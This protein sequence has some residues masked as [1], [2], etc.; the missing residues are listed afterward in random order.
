MAKFRSSWKKIK[1]R[2]QCFLASVVQCS[3]LFK[4]FNICHDLVIQNQIQTVWHACLFFFFQ[5]SDMFPIVCFGISFMD[6]VQNKC[7]N[8][9]KKMF[10]SAKSQ[11]GPEQTSSC[12]CYLVIN[13]LDTILV[14]TSLMS[15]SSIRIFLTV[16]LSTFSVSAIIYSL[17]CQY[18]PIY[19]LFTFPSQ[20][21]IFIA[22][23][24]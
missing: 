13:I 8:S 9:I 18:E 5:I 19:T 20:L 23:A 1:E 16:F 4:K 15:K 21:N 12:Y 10:P 3:T 14:E 7:N 17:H 24:S 2:F 11:D 22:S 6:H